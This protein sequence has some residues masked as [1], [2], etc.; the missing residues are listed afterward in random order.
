MDNSPKIVK[1]FTKLLETQIKRK[2]DLET[3]LEDGVAEL[4]VL[5]GRIN[6]IEEQIENMH[7]TFEEC[8]QPPAK[9]LPLQ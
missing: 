2:K 5:Q 4:N 3:E 1:A 6:E 7:K 8:N 9:E